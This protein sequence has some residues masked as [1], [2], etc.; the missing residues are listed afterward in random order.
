MSEREFGAWSKYAA[1]KGMPWQRIE[2]QLARI[3]MLLDL[4]LGSAQRARLADYMGATLDELL[5]GK[6]DTLA[7]DVEDAFGEGIVIRRGA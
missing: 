7:D 3:A 5:Q 4:G 6:A 2:V 1:Q